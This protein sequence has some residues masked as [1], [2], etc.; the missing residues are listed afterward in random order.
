MNSISD[1]SEATPTAAGCKHIPPA[2]SALPSCYWPAVFNQML[3]CRVHSDN[4]V[5]DAYDS[6][7]LL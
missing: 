7:E 3:W 6:K 4:D 2:I 1:P 5:G